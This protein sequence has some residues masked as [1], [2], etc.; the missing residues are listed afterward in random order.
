MCQLCA[1]LSYVHTSYLGIKDL[2]QFNSPVSNLSSKQWHGLLQESHDGHMDR[3][4]PCMGTYLLILRRLNANS[5][6][7]PYNES[8][9]ARFLPCGS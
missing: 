2:E 3:T 8:Q 7:P 4:E 6:H 1:N 5:Q 9:Q